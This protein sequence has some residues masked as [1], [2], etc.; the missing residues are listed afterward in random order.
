V[1]G[2]RNLESGNDIDIGVTYGSISGLLGVAALESQAVTLVL[3]A[4]GGDETLDLGGLGV[5]LLALALW[6]DFTTDDELADL[7]STREKTRSAFTWL[8]D[9]KTHLAHALQVW[10][11]VQPA[12]EHPSTRERWADGEAAARRAGD[13][14][15]NVVGTY[16][17]ILGEAEELADLGG[18]LG[19]QALGVDDIGQ[20]GDVG[21]ALLDDAEGQNGQVH[22][23]DAATNRLALALTIAASTVAR[24]AVGEQQTDTGWVDDTLLHRETLLVVASSDAEDVALEL[25][26]N[27]VTGD[28]GAHSVRKLSDMHVRVS[29]FIV[30]VYDED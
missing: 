10:L 5:W 26:A 12:T 1:R 15:G 21:L 16:I 8:R 27:A 18:T 20:T 13:D 29:F 17:I 28:L 4:L 23:D 14:D 30:T 11:R 9:S 19:T 24:V 6:L 3:E 25:V 2:V 7:E 22:G